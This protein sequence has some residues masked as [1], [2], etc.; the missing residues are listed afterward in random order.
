[1]GAPQKHGQRS[2]KSDIATYDTTFARSLGDTSDFSGRIVNRGIQYNKHWGYLDRWILNS[3]GDTIHNRETLNTRQNYYHKPQFSLR[4]FWTVN[5]KFYISNIL[6]ASIGNGGGTRGEG[7]GEINGQ[8]DLQT[9][10]NSNVGAG[11]FGPIIDNDHSST[12]YKSGSY[13]KSSINNHYWYGGLSTLNYQATDKFSL[14][15]GIDMRYYK[16]EHYSIVYDL[17]GGDYAI[18]EENQTQNSFIKREGDIIGYHND[19]IVKWS[20]LFSQ[21][22]YS[23]GML[24]AFFN[25]SGSNSAY[26]RIDYFKKKDL[27]L[28]DTTYYEALGT[29]TIFIDGKKQ[30]TYEEIH[31]NGKVY[32]ALS[33]EAAYASTDWKWIRG[34]TI[35]TGANLNLDEYCIF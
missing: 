4:D 1:M 29:S 26:K 20:G 12:E 11:P 14:S 15:G 21:A 32:N 18:D 16:G 23:N 19:G 27:V 10:Y 35:K 34:Y 31:H 7:I 3:N 24:S 33:K 6:Y 17:L 8:Q 9:A 22:E 28:E 25:I 2:Y 5:D 13:L 30:L